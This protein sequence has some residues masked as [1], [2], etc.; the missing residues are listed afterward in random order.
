MQHNL[1][2]VNLKLNII[3]RGFGVVLFIGIILGC[4]AP[5][6]T[7]A[8]VDGKPLSEWLRPYGLPGWGSRDKR[9][10]EQAHADYA[11]KELG[12]HAVPSLLKML[13]SRDSK[14]NFGAAYGFECLG[15]QATGSVPDLVAIYESKISD[16]SQA[17]VA[18]SL[19][20]I[21]KD[22]KSAVP[23]LIRGTTHASEF[24]RHCSLVALLKIRG[25]PQQM[26]PVF[27]RFLADPPNSEYAEIGLELLGWEGDSGEVIALLSGAVNDPNPKVS[28]VA[29]QIV[30]RL[31]SR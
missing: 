19:G 29:K 23:V 22:A 1:P 30:Q 24:V 14:L 5:I 27:L 7:E 18:Q 12:I 16:A 13:R 21:G 15:S 20:G 9:P 6:Q 17:A 10:P 26:V 4:S 28:T 2:P 11:M 3:P 31:N 25:D 8:V